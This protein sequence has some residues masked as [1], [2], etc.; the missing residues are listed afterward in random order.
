MSSLDLNLDLMLKQ[1][2]VGSDTPNGA[3]QTE[4]NQN[5]LTESD[6]FLL[7]EDGLGMPKF[8]DLPE[9]T[10]VGNGEI[11]CFGNPNIESFYITKENLQ[12]ELTPFFRAT[13]VNEADST[14]M[15]YGGLNDGAWQVNRVLKADGT[16]TTATQI[17]NPGTIDLATAWSNKG[18]L[19]YS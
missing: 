19:S 15:Y 6:D 16:K 12:N 11:F 17:N 1:A 5:L 18:T 9:A 14:Y 8:S 2:S 3:L 4:D 10:T 7:T 13:L